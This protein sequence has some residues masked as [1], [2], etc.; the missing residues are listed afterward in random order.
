M[1]RVE[2]DKEDIW[3]PKTPAH[4]ATGYFFCTLVQTNESGDERRQYLSLGSAIDFESEEVF[5]VYGIEAPPEPDG[6]TLCT[7][8]AFKTD[9]GYA[10]HEVATVPLTSENASK[11]RVFNVEAECFRLRFHEWLGLEFTLADNL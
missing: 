3:N 6:N 10:R 9:R 5:V 4:A 7:L 1:Y 2:F 8:S 11:L